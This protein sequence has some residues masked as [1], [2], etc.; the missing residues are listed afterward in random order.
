MS[1]QRPDKR[2]ILFL[3]SDTG[4]GH[5]SAAE[6]II[7][8]IHLE[9]PGQIECEMVDILKEYGPPPINL[10][11]RIYPP[12]SRMPTL[13]G[14]G[15][16]L[17]NGKRRVH[18]F[19]HAIWPYIRRNMGRL[20]SEHPTDL[21]VSVHQL[22]NT[23]IARVAQA[24]GIPFVTVVTDLVTT[25]AAWYAVRASHVIV[26]THEAFLRG[27]KN[28]LQPEQMS[29]IG[30]PVANRFCHQD[31]ADRAANRARLGW[32]ATLPMVLMVGGGEGMGP[33]EEMA[34][35][36]DR[37][38]LPVG[39][40]IVTGRNQALRTRL[41]ERKWRI[42]AHIYGFVREMPQFMNAADILVTKAGPGTISEAFIAGLPMV[43]YSRLPGQE[44]GNVTFVAGTGAGVWAPEPD[45]VVGTLRAWLKDP[46]QREKATQISRS[47]ARP[48]ASREIARILVEHAR[49]H[50]S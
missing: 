43:L 4:G 2:R 12:L 29:E 5:R 9:F 37:A 30:L 28:G 34:S 47:L 46:A 21:L 1:L 40:A 8:A 20:V 42:P 11:P 27:L 32:H 6:A 45:Q 41:E 7:E 36:I 25:H 3:F 16:K 39:L 48:N 33:L 10:A 50:P 14:F 35:A 18:A 49:S 15:Y 44:D 38:N 31:R 23:P 17:S 13:W 22:I 26:P 24:R 19:Y